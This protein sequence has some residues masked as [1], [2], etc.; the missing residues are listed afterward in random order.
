MVIGVGAPLGGA[1][2][3][4][5]SD[6]PTPSLMVIL[7]LGGAGLGLVLWRETRSGKS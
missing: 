6:R 2:A 1:M 4:V 7:A 5:F 3:F